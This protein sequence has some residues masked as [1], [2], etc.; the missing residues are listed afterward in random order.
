[1][2]IYW[3]EREGRL[4]YHGYHN[5]AQFIISTSSCWCSHV[6]IHA[7]YDCRYI[8]TRPWRRGATTL[9]PDEHEQLLQIQFGWTAPGT[10][11]EC[12]KRIGASFIGTSVQ[13]DLALYTLCFMAGGKENKH[14]LMV[15]PYKT[16]IVCHVMGHGSHMKIGT[17][18]PACAPMTDEEAAVRWCGG[19]SIAVSWDRRMRSAEPPRRRCSWGKKQ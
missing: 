15:G 12:L 5:Y 11:E 7:L 18:Y 10:N 2:R 4:D 6:C 14:T 19:S 3:E 1:M 8:P 17:I 9:S 16:E 13:F